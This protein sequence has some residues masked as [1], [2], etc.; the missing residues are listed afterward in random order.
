MQKNRQLI[1]LAVLLSLI[2][3]WQSSY[4]QNSISGKIVDAGSRQ[5][6]EYVTVHDGVVGGK[7]TSS[8]QYG[9]FSFISKDKIELLYF[10][11][12]GYKPTVVT[13]KEKTELIIEL[14]PDILNLKDV[15]ILQNNSPT[16]F[17]TLSRIDLNLK[18]VRNTQEVL[19]LVPGLFIAQHAGGGKAEQIFLRG[20]DSDHGTDVQVSVDGMPVNMV[21]HAH[22]QGYADAHF[23]IPE[24]INNIDFGAGPYYTQHGNLNTAGYISFGTFTNIPANRVQIEVGNFNTYR[25]LAMIDLIKKDKDKQSAWIA[26]EFNFTNGPT[27]YEQKFERF[28]IFGKYNLAITKRT[29]FTASISSFSSKWNASGQVPDRA[30]KSGLIN[31]FGSIDPSEGG[32]T[33]RHNANFLLAHKFTNGVVWENQVY[34]SRY[35]FDLY[36]NFSFFL[37]DTINGDAIKQAEMRN[38]FGYQSQASQ[39]YSLGRF[40]LRSNYGIGIRHDATE[41]SKLANV[42]KREFLRNIKLGDIK[43]TNAFGYLQQQFSWSRWL[44][45]AGVRLDYFYFDYE[46]KLNSMQQPAQSKSIISPKIN[47][48]YTQSPE[49]QIY[50]KTGKG[51]HSNDT[52]VVVAKGAREILPAAYGF[53]LGIILKP[54]QNLLINIAVWYLHL[55]Q[56][57]VYVGDDGNVEPSGETR[58]KGIEIIARYQF[59]KHI[60]ANMNLNFTKPRAIGEKTGEDFIPLAPTATSTGGLFYQAKKGFNGS[61]TYRYMKNRPANEDNSIVAKGYCLFD[62][63]LNYTH[64]NYEIGLAMENLL[65]TKWN[66]AQFATTSRLRNEVGETTELNFTPGTPYFMRLKFAIFF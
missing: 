17:N 32:N 35:A 45:D 59:S 22:G 28:N 33:Q 29:Q 57:F 10:S 12:V 63:S 60:F 47:I 26:S 4:C 16:K 14:Q 31:R 3:P 27:H 50:V 66:E 5:P 8:D 52:R 42:V 25:G 36:S 20:F 48:Q 30:V 11:Y 39:K 46:D 1:I 40:M 6:L 56:E 61:I 18:P 64:P 21:S 53:D 38:V 43:E 37:N 49:I 44:I 24:T 54:K 62:A 2:I 55:N 23:I 58:R 65:N 13:T 41:D 7:K 34:Y 15:V 9:N 19:R 51:F